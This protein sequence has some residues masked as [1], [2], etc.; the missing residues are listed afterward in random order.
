MLGKK[1][2]DGAANLMRLGVALISSILIVPLFPQQGST[3]SIWPDADAPDRLQQTIREA[4]CADASAATMSAKLNGTSLSGLLASPSATRT[5]FYVSP[6]GDDSWSGLLPAANA[7]RNDGPFASIEHAR[8]AARKKGGES[9]IAMGNGDYYLTQPIVFDAR[10]AGLIIAARCNET[11]VLHG[12]PRVRN[13][14]SRGNGRWMAPLKL[15]PQEEVGD[16]FVDGVRQ[17]GARFPNA[18]V[19]GDPRKGWLFAAK[20]EPPIGPWQGNTRFCFH[21]GDLPAL[22]NA[23]SLSVSI[24]GGFQ[25]GSQWGNDTLPVVSIDAASRTIDTRGTSYFFTAEGS[26]YFLTGTEAF[27]DAPG[28]WWY[29]P[30]MGQI[31]YITA[32]RSFPDGAVVAGILPTF[33]RLAGADGM[34]VSGL[35][36]R[37]GAPQ[38]SGKVDTDTRGFGAIRLEGTNRVKLLGNVIEN[39]GVGIH[40]SESQDVLI[41]GNTIGN[42]AGNGIYVGTTYGSFG[43]SNGARI[44]SNHIHDVGQVYYETAGIS[45]QATD[46]IRIA[47][48]LIENLAQFGIGGGSAWGPQ[49]AVHDA[50][51]EHNVIR[52]AN[53]RTA[54]GGAI[55]LMGE[56][57]DPLNS[58]ISDNLVTGTGHLMNRADGTF[59]PPGYDNID[60]WPTP[61]SW[62]IYTDGRASG[63]RIEG[64]TLSGN[65]SAIGINGG[66]SNLVTGNLISHGSGVVFRVDDSTG[67]GWHPQWARPNRIEEN[68]VSVDNDSGIAASVN[69]PDHGIGFVHFAR[70]RYSGNLNDKSFRLSWW[71]TL[72]GHSG[73]LSDL[74]KAG[75]DTGSVVVPNDK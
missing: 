22:G 56:Q 67:R 25:P 49:D 57:G 37:N 16:L 71:N 30:T 15:P 53:Q 6:D 68:V 65:V 46:N 54:D 31:R 23:T 55:K 34:I 48:N 74:Q 75:V 21:P 28:E 33:F 9:I 4:T 13:W 3:T 47:Y 70:N 58:I 19:D 27:L 72:W 62:A 39:I 43:K 51:I 50:V 69:A 17:T 12:G 26:R 11:P 63:V 1:H 41:A 64:N 60:E 66:W 20:C 42:V 35:Q 73:S 14:T 45:F 38:G 52:N 5:T 44:L 10:D 40:V 7:K 61:I 59:W 24:V 32:D 36:F 18:P 8:D 2:E 29:D